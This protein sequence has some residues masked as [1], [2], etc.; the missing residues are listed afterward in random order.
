[1]ILTLNDYIDPA[2]KQLLS[3]HKLDNFAVLW[4]LELPA[5]DR[6][7]TERGGHSIV[8]RL[9]LAGHSFYL[10]RQTNHLTRSLLKPLGEPTFAREFRM[11]QLYQQLGIPSLKVAWFGQRQTS[12][13]QQAILLTHALDGWQDLDYWL[14]QWP[15]LEADTQ[16]AIL[17]AC[18]ELARQLH[19]SGRMHG[20]FYPKH[21]FLQQQ[22]QGFVACLI[23]LE[24]TRRLWLGRRDKIKDLDPLFRRTR[25]VLG[26]AEHK[27][28]LQ[29]YL[30]QSENNALVE[31]W[32]AALKRRH[33]DKDS[34]A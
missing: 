34:R 25:H 15:Q 10:K 30:Q 19:A 2:I 26:A 4:Q 29:A 8:A 21:I 16:Q 13:G 23:D 22:Q 28:F 14:Q 3:Q 17:A 9:E 18:G 31:N 33:A 24:K 6:P 5:V 11:I 7:N 20:C 1:M 12:E 32:F 27:K